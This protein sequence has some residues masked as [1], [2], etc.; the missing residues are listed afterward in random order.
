MNFPTRSKMKKDF[1]SGTPSSIPMDTAIQELG[2]QLHLFL[3]TEDS[4]FLRDVLRALVFFRCRLEGVLDIFSVLLM[5]RNTSTRIGAFR[6]GLSLETADLKFWVP[7]VAS[8]VF[9]NFAFNCYFH[10]NRVRMVCDMD[11]ERQAHVIFKIRKMR[12]I[13]TQTFNKRVKLKRD[14]KIQ[15]V[16]REMMSNRYDFFICN[17]QEPE[18]ISG[19]QCASG[20]SKLFFVLTDIAE[21]TAL[22]TNDSRSMQNAII[23]HN[24]LVHS[25]S[26]FFGGFISRY[27]GDSFLLVFHTLE[28]AIRFSLELQY[29][30]MFVN[31]NRYILQNN[32]YCV[33]RH[34]PTIYLRGLQVRISITG[35]SVAMMNFY[36]NVSFLG[37][38]IK[39]LYLINNKTYG[40]ET[41]ISE[42]ICYSQ[43]FASLRKEFYLVR[44]NCF[45]KRGLLV[46]IHPELLERYVFMAAHP[47][48]RE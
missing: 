14:Q 25:L 13:Y 18:R 45:L 47:K 11:N 5:L 29:R 38:P 3:K 40:G 19:C 1:C 41:S 34:P 48:R 44:R 23:M 28:N 2:N 33:S 32:F 35:G 36:K 37:N 16:Y 10:I 9:L 15:C 46:I 7:L 43:E 12:P 39:E 27:E 17:V 31:W 21:S 42:D 30:L 26:R 4:S 22:W 8:W 24:K 6:E 20:P